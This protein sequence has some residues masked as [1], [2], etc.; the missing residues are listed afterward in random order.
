MLF[1]YY[2]WLDQFYLLVHG[3]PT[4]FKEKYHGIVP[5]AIEEEVLEKVELHIEAER[6]RYDGFIMK[7]CKN[8]KN[9]LTMNLI[10]PK[11]YRPQ[12]YKNIVRKV[13]TSSIKKTDFSDFEDD[14]LR[15]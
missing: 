13:Y 3:E 9:K 11:K 12:E 2:Y 1:Y 7:C 14:Q 5:S 8:Q 15:T 6:K 10:D 4:C